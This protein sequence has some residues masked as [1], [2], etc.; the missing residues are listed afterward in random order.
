M[1]SK[2]AISLAYILLKPGNQKGLSACNKK[3]EEAIVHAKK[4]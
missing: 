1:T 3:E 2:C 4:Q